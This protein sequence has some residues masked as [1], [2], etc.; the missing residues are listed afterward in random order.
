LEGRNAKNIGFDRCHCTAYVK[1][2]ERPHEVEKIRKQD[3]IGK[4]AIDTARQADTGFEWNHGGAFFWNNGAVIAHA[5]AD[6][7][8]GDR[9]DTIKINGVYSEKSNRMLQV[10]RYGTGAGGSCPVVLENYRFA[11]QY[12][13][14]DGEV[15]QCEAAGPLS[16]IGC[17]MEPGPNDNQLRIRYAPRPAPDPTPFSRRT[18]VFEIPQVMGDRIVGRWVV[19]RRPFSGGGARLMSLLRVLWT[20]SRVRVLWDSAR[21]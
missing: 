20:P 2:V 7:R 17:D 21:R 3:R 19:A 12:A 8:I 6:F 15:I 4:Y 13:A 1:D 10:P 14:D 5:E 9:N 18:G 11:G 16:M